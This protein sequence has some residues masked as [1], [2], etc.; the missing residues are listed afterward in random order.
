MGLYVSYGP[1]LVYSKVIKESFLKAD[2]ELILV[3]TDGPV[4][5]H[6]CFNNLV[7][8]SSSFLISVI[9]SA[10]YLLKI[11]YHQMIEQGLLA[12]VERLYARAD[13]HAG[14]PSIR[15]VGYRQIW[16]YLDGKM[17][18]DEAIERA[19]IATGQ[20]AKRQ[21]TWL[22]AMPDRHHLDC[23]NPNRAKAV[24]DVVSQHWD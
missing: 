8:M 10:A 19:I 16:E 11:P 1:S 23:M 15:S 20:L 6:R 18:L 7:S 5:Y 2:R 9:H 13:L 24:V 4:R 14:L 3:E 21:M 12:E 17:G 22:R